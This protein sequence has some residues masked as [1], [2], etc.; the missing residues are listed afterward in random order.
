[1]GTLT[2]LRIEG[3]DCGN[4]ARSVT[5]ALQGVP[6][7]S[8][9]VVDLQGAM[10]RTYWMPGQAPEP[11]RLIEAV[12]RAGYQACLAENPGSPSPAG[13]PPGNTLLNPWTTA[14]WL[15]VPATLLLLTGDWIG[16]WGMQR[17]FQ[18]LSLV[19]ASAVQAGVGWRFYRGAWRQARVGRS[20]MDTLVSLGSSSAYL[21]SLWLFFTQSHAHLFFAESVSILT[22]ISVGHALEARMS[23]KAGNA[24]RALMELAPTT[25]RRLDSEAREVDTPVSQ[26]RPG[27][28]LRIKPGDQIPVDAIVLEGDSSADESL[29]T[30]EPMPVRKTSGSA[31][32]AGSA[33]VEGS[34][35]VRVTATGE[36]TTL[37]R[38]AAVVERAQSSRASIQRLADRVSSVFVPVVVMIACVS[39][40][41]WAWAPETLRH[42][43]S[44]LSPLLWHPQ[45]SLSPMSDAVSAFCSVLIVACPCAMGLATPVALM[46]GINAA[47]RRGILIRDAVALEKTGRISALAFDKTGT[48]T[49]GH[50]SITRWED[51]RPE[52]FRSIPLPALAGLLA[53]R[54]QHPVSRAVSAAGKALTHSNPASQPTMPALT[55]WRELRGQGI[56]AVAHG[57][58]PLQPFRLGSLGWIRS[59]GVTLDR[60]AETSLQLAADAGQSVLLL[61]EGTMLLGILHIGDAIRPDSPEVVRRLQAQ[62]TE[63]WLISGD[64]D[65]TCQAVAKA[66]GIPPERVRAEC[67]PEDKVRILGEI[68]A[69]GLQVAFVGDGINDSPALAAANL[70]IA[71]AKASDVAR[72]AADIV[73]LRPDLAAVVEALNLA[74]RTLR[75]IRQN[76]FWAFFY[77]A[78][79]VPLAALGYLSPVV[80]ALTMGLSDLIVIGNALRLRRRASTPHRNNGLS[81]EAKDPRIKR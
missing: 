76:L 47:A 19:L 49:A 70:G 2:E 68:Q 79:A 15:G 8:R 66:V 52:N 13:S 9:S 28:R 51:L 75:T 21:W 45:A 77:N 1:M 53:D 7:V 59:L 40:A 3:M 26:L 42:W 11:A 30:G 17:G 44:F 24:L 55:S 37:A 74:D 69:R 60:N 65:P 72:E 31:L 38:I 34:L 36:H 58:D 39:A 81:G 5:E 25:A 32:L 67:R 18:T 43:Q 4:C 57:A 16:G 50:P 41:A 23:S 27:E 54:S 61:V 35:V 10:A 33:N 73:L 48:L 46:A 63:T 29:L 64:T 14:V 22:L 20:N 56:E 12:E 6:G 71:V 62:G 80:C 78:A